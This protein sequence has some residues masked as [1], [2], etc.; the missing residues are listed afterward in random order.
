MGEFDF[1][2]DSF[3][4]FLKQKESLIH[5]RTAEGIQDTDNFKNL[6]RT[7]V[8]YH[9]ERPIGD[10]TALMITKI[11]IESLIE[12]FRS[13]LFNELDSQVGVCNNHLLFNR[14]LEISNF[15]RREIKDNNDARRYYL[16]LSKDFCVFLISPKGVHYFVD[17]NDIGESVFFTP[18]TLKSYNELKDITDIL[19]IFNDYRIHLKQQDNYSKFF[20][21]NSSK[22]SL[23]KHLDSTA[24]KKEYAAFL[25]RHTQLLENSPENAFREDLRMYLTRKLKA[26]VLAK[27]YILENFK[28]LDIY[29][30]DD[31]GE[32]YLIE[33][34]WVGVSI[35]A[36]G[37]LIG[38]SYNAGHI[39]PK[40]VEQSVDYIR[41]LNDEGK[42]IKLGY[43]AV[44]DAR[45]EDL[46]DTV[47]TFDENNLLSGSQKYYTRFNKIPDFR[48]INFHPV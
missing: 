21:S 15:E 14:N 23:C 12:D 41:Q 45:K 38:T 39:N 32:L 34:K 25:A 10:F 42:N 43:L 11:E 22:K 36:N 28:R 7:L 24:D 5:I 27:E 26:N 13:K 6:H 33:V 29:I 1:T 8:S 16:E 9:S 47:E 3:K 2:K 40:A 44:F 4:Q 18:D 20:A 30:N 17:G 37:Q 48:V 46:P 31:F 19:E 35:H